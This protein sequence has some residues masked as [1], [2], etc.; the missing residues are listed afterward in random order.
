M[1]FLL[2]Q[3]GAGLW[4]E[5]GQQELSS[6]HSPIVRVSKRKKMYSVA[7]LEGWNYTRQYP[8]GCYHPRSWGDQWLG[9]KRRVQKWRESLSL[10][11]L[12]SGGCWQSWLIVATLSLI[13]WSMDSN[14][15]GY[16]Y[17]PSGFLI[18]RHLWWLL[19][20]LHP[21]VSRINAPHDLQL[22]S[23]FCHRQIIF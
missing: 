21:R 10:L 13:L 14:P 23:V 17:F 19:P 12:D 18:K 22:N 11:T 16:V 3:K 5:A 2:E 6:K 1:Y 20:H 9:C 8:G 15:F 4:R 7:F